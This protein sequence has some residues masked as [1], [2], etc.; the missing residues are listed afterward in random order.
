[1]QNHL[2]TFGGY[3]VTFCFEG[4]GGLLPGFAQPR[5]RTGLVAGPLSWRLNPRDTMAGS[6]TMMV[7]PFAVI[8][9]RLSHLAA[10]IQQPKDQPA[11]QAKRRGE[12]LPAYADIVRTDGEQ[13]Q[14]AVTGSWKGTNVAL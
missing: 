4:R 13:N 3:A 7:A 2:P 14:V 1:M 8:P 5:A 12:R 6:A 11:Q 10:R 9:L